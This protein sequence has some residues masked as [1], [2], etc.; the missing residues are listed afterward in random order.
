MD[1]AFAQGL[2]VT[3]LHNHF[4]FDQP[5]VY[6]MHIGGMGPT[7]QLAAGVKAVW[8]AIKAVRS[9]RPQ[10]AEGFGDR[11]QRLAS[12]TQ[13]RSHTSWDTRPRSL[14]AWPR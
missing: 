1:A 8:D 13:M 11:R 4:F 9:G 5:K 14:T 7:D 2:S 10:P 6:F 3:G 12:W